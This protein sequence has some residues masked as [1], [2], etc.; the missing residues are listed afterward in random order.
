M[1]IY[2]FL[3]YNRCIYTPRNAYSFCLL[4]KSAISFNLR[5]PTNLN[6]NLPSR[7][8][9]SIPI[10]TLLLILA[11][12]GDSPHKSYVISLACILR[13]D[14]IP[15]KPLCCSNTFSTCTFVLALLLF[16]VSM[17]LISLANWFL[18]VFFL[19]LVEYFLDSRQRI[20]IFFK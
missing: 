7:R 3:F 9:I 12:W 14:S 8:K 18:F 15:T 2:V 19:F 5:F 20:L 11:I 6:S 10:P 16:C 4:I 1:I 17:A 13:G